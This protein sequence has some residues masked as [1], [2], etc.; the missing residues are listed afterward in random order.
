MSIVINKTLTSI[1]T[2]FPKFIIQKPAM[3]YVAGE[4]WEEAIQEVQKLNSIGFL[5]TL[6]ILGEHSTTVEEIEKVKNRYL[7]LFDIIEKKK[8]NCTISLKLTHLGLGY[9]TSLAEENLFEILEKAKEY[10]NFLRID[11]ENSP[12][13][14]ETIRLF[15]KCR[16]LYHN[17]GIAFQSYLKRSEEDLTQLFRKDLNVRICK[18]IYHESPDIAFQNRE[19]IRQNFIQLVQIGLETNTY[20]AIATHDL[21]LIDSLET[22]IVNKGIKKSRYEFQVLYGV[23]MRGRLESL[24][25]AGHKVRIYIPF[26][27]DWYSYAI[28]RLE[29]NP[30][31]ALYILKNLFIKR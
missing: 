27:N 7:K 1:L 29:E 6:D 15:K 2:L 16:D 10:N 23:P 26:G 21:Y 19:K 13:T 30:H 14:D 11:M 22:W 8:L 31:M 4:T 5:T 25:S 3:R 20:I 12:Y 9:F 24:L 28:R 18:G 17:I